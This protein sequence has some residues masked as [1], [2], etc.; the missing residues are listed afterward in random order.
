MF[1]FNMHL[2]AENLYK[3]TSR[4]FASSDVLKSELKRIILLNR[5]GIYEF[6]MIIYLGLLSLRD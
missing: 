2:Q 1:F 3:I 5:L 6:V 4:T